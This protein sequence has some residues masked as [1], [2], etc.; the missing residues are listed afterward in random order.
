MKSSAVWQL[1]FGLLLLMVM[2][3]VAV[4]AKR[5]ISIGVLL[6]LIPFQTIDTRYASSSALIA[7]VMG[8]ALLIGGD[9]KFR[10]VPA[11]SLIVLSYFVSLSLADRSILTNHVIFMFQFFSCLVVFVLA[12]NFAILVDEERAVMDLLLAINVLAI[13]YCALQLSVGPGERYIPL[14]V[15]EFKFNLNRHPGDPRLVGP[16]D[17][18]G[19]TAGYFALMT[20]VCAFQIMFSTGRRRFLVWI[21][22]GFNLMGL[23]ATGNRAGFLVLLAASPLLL[24]AYRKE[25][26]ARRVIQYSIAGMA[27]FAVAAAIAVTYTDFN[28]MFT[29]MDTVTNTE[30][31]I[32]ATRAEG[33]PVAI[34]KIRVH[35]WFGEGPHFWTAEDAEDVGQL[36][37]EFD[38]EGGVSTAFDHYPHSLYLY[39]LRTVGIFGFLAV[40]GFFVRTWFVLYRA[41]GRQSITDY[42]SAIVRLGLFLIPAFLISQITLEFNRPN[43][44]D[45]AQFIFA[46]MGLLVGVSDRGVTTGESAPGSAIAVVK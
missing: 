14:G 31:G 39:L 7:Y 15:D 42:R 35:P 41:T 32:P 22:T 29:R 20:L 46:L 30:G 19:S 11:L 16:F 5:K 4:G 9:L 33:W 40:I 43:T 45:Y 23:V 34:A 6:L 13:I 37:A 28:Q 8:A 25:L 10:M 26:G 2:F 24:F 21:V 12:Y 44:M 36:Q 1:A 27:V 17:N 18:P 38:E 3:A